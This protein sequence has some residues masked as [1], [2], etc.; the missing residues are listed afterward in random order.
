MRL[1]QKKG[2]RVGHDTSIGDIHEANTVV[3]ETKQNRTHQQPKPHSPAAHPVELRVANIDTGGMGRKRHDHPAHDERRREARPAEHARVEG[4]LARERART[5]PGGGRLRRR[6]PAAPASRAA[7][8]A[9]AH[10]PR[11]APAVVPLPLRDDAALFLRGGVDAAA[12]EAVGF[13]IVRVSGERQVAVFVAVAGG[14]GGPQ[15]GRRAGGDRRRPQRVP[16]AGGG[17]LLGVLAGDGDPRDPAEERG[18]AHEED[19]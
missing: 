15:P 5:E 12:Q 18:A 17:R 6:P 9:A 2:I 16:P 14:L 7:A 13:F 8:A 19:A 1:P 11:P 4:H 3:I 10:P